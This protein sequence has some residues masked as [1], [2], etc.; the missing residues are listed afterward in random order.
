MKRHSISTT[1][2]PCVGQK[3]GKWLQHKDQLR[4]LQQKR[5]LQ[6]SLRRSCAELH[7][8]DLEYRR[9]I[10]WQENS[11][12]GFWSRHTNTSYSDFYC[13]REQK[14]TSTIESESTNIDGLN[15]RNGDEELPKAHEKLRSSVEVATFDDTVASVSENL[16]EIVTEAN[17]TL[18]TSGGSK[19]VSKIS[20]ERSITRYTGSDLV[21][22]VGGGGGSDV[23]GA[24][25]GSWPRVVAS[26]L[27]Q[28]STLLRKLAV[29]TSR[30]TL[31][32]TS[33][34]AA[35]Q[36]PPVLLPRRKWRNR[37]NRQRKRLRR[38]FTAAAASTNTATSP[39]TVAKNTKQILDAFQANERQ[40]CERALLEQS[41]SPHSSNSTK[42]RTTLRPFA[43]LAK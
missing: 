38:L 35:Q 32:S 34:S 33:A 15:L 8:R 19:I 24:A 14:H 6:S 7:S 5:Y 40:E 21:C 12:R 18:P 3:G 29:A 36:L 10:S 39:Q 25:D 17:N 23:V 30:G 1:S 22:G 31:S 26:L 16:N 43:R 42:D 41:L 2:G 37:R 4:K 27:A 13:H 9:Q 28:Q 20:N 11:S